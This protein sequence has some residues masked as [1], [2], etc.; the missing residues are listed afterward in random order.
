MAPPV[1]LPPAAASEPATTPTTATPMPPSAAPTPSDG[2]DSST[3]G[4]PLA[5]RASWQVPEGSVWGPVPQG[6]KK[7]PVYA[8]FV[9]EFNKDGSGAVYPTRYICVHKDHNGHPVRVAHCKVTAN[10]KQHLVGK[11]GV[12]VSS[13]HVGGHAAGG[14]SSGPCGGGPAVANA[15][16][17]LEQARL[18]SYLKSQ[19]APMSPSHLQQQ[20]FNNR[21]LDMIVSTLSPAS[22][23]DDESYKSIIHAA[24][25]LLSVMSRSSVGHAVTRRFKGH[26]ELV[27]A[28]LTDVGV[29]H[30]NSDMWTSAANEAFG[31]F[32]VTWLDDKWL[33]KTPVLRC[34]IVEGRHTAFAIAAFLLQVSWDFG[35]SQKVGVVP[36]DG[37]SHCVAAGGVVGDVA[38]QLDDGEDERDLRIMGGSGRGVAGTVASRIGGCSGNGRCA[39]GGRYAFGAR[40]SSQRLRSRGRNTRI[41][42]GG[43]RSRDLCSGVFPSTMAGAAFRGD[44]RCLSEA[45]DSL[46]SC[47]FHGVGVPAVVVSG[48]DGSEIDDDEGGDG[49]DLP[50][51]GSD[52]GSEDVADRHVPA[53]ACVADTASDARADSFCSDMPAALHNGAWQA[54]DAANGSSWLWQHARC[55]THTLQLSVRAGLAVPAVRSALQK[56]RL[57]AKLCR[58]STNFQRELRVAVEK[59]EAAAAEQ[60]GRERTATAKLVSRLIINCPTRWSS[61]LAMLRR[62]VRVGPAVPSALSTYYH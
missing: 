5:P 6:K 31:S 29:C 40:S 3:G 15:R 45:T 50:E 13:M 62:F 46:S 30:V 34:C 4:L 8:Y 58:T 53:A 12:T 22:M 7:S 26:Q 60:D 27:R 17:S 33:L 21:Q 57:V 38:G 35:P 11:H 49:A 24:N 39:R 36:T 52:C 59:D 61:T 9:C 23:V 1:A 18:P 19:L 48:R 41:D 14:R 44:N 37:A 2:D 43:G 25:S 32:V 20:M 28:A 42:W 55:A 16:P 51:V 10:L 47:D 56:V 54:T